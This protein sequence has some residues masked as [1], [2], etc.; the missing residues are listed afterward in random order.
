MESTNISMP[1]ESSNPNLFFNLQALKNILR[2]R[3]LLKQFCD[4]TN[5]RLKLVKATERLKMLDAMCQFF[6]F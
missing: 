3:D 4:Y 2:G 6:P 5:T 1:E